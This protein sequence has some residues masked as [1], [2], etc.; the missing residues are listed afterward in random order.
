MNT[1]EKGISFEIPFFYMVIWVKK[2]KTPS[3]MAWLLTTNF[4]CDKIRQKM[5]KIINKMEELEDD[6]I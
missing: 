3:P 2:P 6:I 4:A 5:R 1:D